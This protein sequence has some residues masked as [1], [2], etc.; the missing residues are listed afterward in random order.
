MGSV[1]MALLLQGCLLL[2]LAI[3]PSFSARESPRHYYSCP[4]GEKLAS[5]VECPLGHVYNTRDQICMRTQGEPEQMEVEVLGRPAQLGSLYD[6][7]VSM[8]FPEAS[9]WSKETVNEY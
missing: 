4:E 3:C 5:L 6:A 1:R 8:F 7:R 9:L 2:L